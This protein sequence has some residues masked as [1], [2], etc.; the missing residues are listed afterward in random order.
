MKRPGL[1]LKGNWLS[2]AGVLFLM[3]ALVMGVASNAKA[4]TGSFDRDR[5]LPEKAGGND[6]IVRGFL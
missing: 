6:Y 2:M 4:A 5:Y 3:L 1:N